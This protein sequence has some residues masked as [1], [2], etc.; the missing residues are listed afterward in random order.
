MSDTLRRFL[1][2]SYHLVFVMMFSNNAE[3]VEAAR[4]KAIMAYKD[5]TQD[6]HDELTSRFS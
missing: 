6:D 2:A 4:T 3:A 1:Q 5:L